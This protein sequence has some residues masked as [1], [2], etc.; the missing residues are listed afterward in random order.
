MMACAAWENRQNLR[1]RHQ[2]REVDGR[3][4]AL[5]LDIGDLERREV[6]VA[7]G[8]QRRTAGM[9]CVDGDGL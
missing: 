7:A 9:A 6:Y 3:P 1:F 4:W 8:G 2:V 5:V